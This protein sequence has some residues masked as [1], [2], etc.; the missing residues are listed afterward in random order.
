MG[1][2]GG[3]LDRTIRVVLGLAAWLTVAIFG[4]H[5]LTVLLMVVGL[6]LVVTGV[7]GYCPSYRFLGINTARAAAGGDTG[8]AGRS[9]V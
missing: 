1:V 8:T 9:A 4:I 6:I 2:N 3:T 7:I 5:P